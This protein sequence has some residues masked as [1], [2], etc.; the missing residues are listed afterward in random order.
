M[1]E[2][3]GLEE[4]LGNLNDDVQLMC[5]QYNE[6]IQGIEEEDFGL[7]ID[8][9]AKVNEDLNPAMFFYTWSSNV[10]ENYLQR[11]LKSTLEF[12]KLVRELNETKTSMETIAT[13][14]AASKIMKINPIDLYSF[15]EVQEAFEHTVRHDFE[16]ILACLEKVRML[17]GDIS[18]NVK[19]KSKYFKT[20][21]S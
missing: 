6:A 21:L 18:V 17:F 20:R 8:Y 10:P 7:F 2:L 12:K 5:H 19:I 9:I 11:Q 15:S 13:N 14:L 3:Y 16:E 4:K 1:Q